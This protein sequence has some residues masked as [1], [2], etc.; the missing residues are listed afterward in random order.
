M[1]QIV[2]PWRFPLRCGN[3]ALLEQGL[4]RAS[5]ARAAIRPST[6]G[7]VPYEGR[8]RRNGEFPSASSTQIMINLIGNATVDR[9]QT[10]FIKFRLA[11]VQG[12]F[13]PVV[14]ADRQVQQFPTPDACGEQQDDGEADRLW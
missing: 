14:V 13:P 7:G 4:E 2:N 12:R 11:D 3:A 9:K 1:P 8:I 6:P 10:G 5:Q